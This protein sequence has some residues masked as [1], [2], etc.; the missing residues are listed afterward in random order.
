MNLK[1]YNKIKE[2]RT[3]QIKTKIK[4]IKYRVGVNRF[5]KVQFGNLSKSNMAN[6][7]GILLLK[8]IISYLLLEYYLSIKIYQ[9]YYFLCIALNKLIVTYIFYVILFFTNINQIFK[10]LS[11]NTFRFFLKRTR[12]IMLNDIDSKQCNLLTA[13]TWTLVRPCSSPNLILA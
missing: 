4:I 8:Y 11:P 1:N 10:I 3:T 2:S 6:S 9:I 7:K 12:D 13:R 5:K